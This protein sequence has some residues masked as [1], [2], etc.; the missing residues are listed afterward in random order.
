VVLEE[1]QQEHEG[2]YRLHRV[3]HPVILHAE[4]PE[5]LLDL[6]EEIVTSA[7][8]LSRLETQGSRR[9]PTEMAR[10]GFIADSQ[11]DAIQRLQDAIS[12]VRAQL[13]RGHPVRMEAQGAT[14][15]PL[16]PAAP[17]GIYYRRYG[18]DRESGQATS[19]SS[20]TGSV[21]AMFPGQGAQYLEMGKTLVVNFPPLR[22]AFGKMDRLFLDE[23]AQPVS[24]VVFP[25]PAF[26]KGT[27]RA[28]GA[29]LQSTHYAQTAIGAFS[30]GLYA[31]L[32]R[33]GFQPDF[34]LGHSFGELP[35]LWAAG[36]LEDDDFFRLVK[37]RGRAMMPPDDPDFDAGGML[38]V[39]G[40]LQMV[41]Q[42]V[43]NL[44][45]V[46]IA[47][48]NSNEQVVLAGPTEDIEH[49][50][51]TLKGKGYVSTVLPVSAAF[52][53]SLVEHASAPF[54]D[55]VA[56]TPFHAPQIPVYANTTGEPYP[57]DT[58]AAKAMLANHMLNPVLFKR[59]IENIYAAG[60]RVFVEIG[61]RS[62]LTHLVEN[63]LA[64]KPH[65]AIALNASRRR[66]SDRQFRDAV[67]QLRVVGLP[68]EDIDPYQA[69]A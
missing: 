65:I 52:H 67:V 21:V 39:K 69:S 44:P 36:V 37:A 19:N 53:T 16:G 57:P 20:S 40:D 32:K 8:P 62:I 33:A 45:G 2:P 24:E 63:I 13:E 9:I 17:Q 34:V 25:P 48:L 64:D 61:P 22:R 3:A 49:A 42:E 43:E 4:T 59:Q 15:H 66:D 56:S 46:S 11:E 54:A 58:E 29:L 23:G 51:E 50:Y 27:Q 7:D 60:G 55:A 12:M 35:A 18:I 5:Q 1:Y 26:D 28:Q 14:D 10:L 6:C 47:N 68:L 30:A 41:E 31:L 38:A